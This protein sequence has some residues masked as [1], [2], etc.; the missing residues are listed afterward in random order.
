VR[1]QVT[2]DRRRAGAVL[3]SLGLAVASATAQEL[4]PRACAPNPTGGNIV[5]LAYG[6]ST[7]GVLFHPALQTVWFGRP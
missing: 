4:T 7:G 3:L 1:F 6:R 5:V 2:L